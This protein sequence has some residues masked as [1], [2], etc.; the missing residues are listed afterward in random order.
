MGFIESEDGD[1]I[2]ILPSERVAAPAP[3]PALS[4]PRIII[5]DK[6]EYK[7]YITRNDNRRSTTN[8]INTSPAAVTKMTSLDLTRY[9]GLWYEWAR[10]PNWFQ[11]KDAVNVTAEYT[12]GPGGMLRVVNTEYVFKP[13]SMLR[14]LLCSGCYY[15]DYHYKRRQITGVGLTYVPNPDH[16]FSYAYRSASSIV[17]NQLGI[18]FDGLLGLLMVGSYVVVRIDENDYQWAIVTDSLHHPI[19]YAWVLTRTPSIDEGTERRILSELDRLG[20][21]Q[22]LFAR[23]EHIQIR[24]DPNSQNLRN[25]FASDSYVAAAGDSDNLSLLE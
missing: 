12:P 25:P 19:K 5:S 21:N 2:D 20:L 4:A 3:A 24:E 17:S 23:T 18:R 1:F 10:I 13:R 8:V 22:E 6:A 16:N 9:A 11:D 14:H 7:T 15:P